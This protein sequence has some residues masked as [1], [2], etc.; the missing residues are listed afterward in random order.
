MFSYGHDDFYLPSEGAVRF[1]GW[2]W[3]KDPLLLL[4]RQRGVQWDDLHI[5]DLGP[6]LID[7]P[8]DALAGFINFLKDES[9]MINPRVAGVCKRPKSNRF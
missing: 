1:I 8:L 2:G 7:L 6:Q 3:L 9:V 5:A 4:G